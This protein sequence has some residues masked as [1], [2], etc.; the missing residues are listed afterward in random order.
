MEL[1]TIIMSQDLE[2]EIADMVSDAKVDCYVKMTDAYGVSHA[3]EGIIGE[4]ME[5]D[6][7][8][9]MITGER[10]NLEELAEKVQK[11]MSEKEFKPCVRMMLTPV[12]KVWM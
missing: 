10:K 1:L 8:L 9:M 11:K 2:H 7:T 6:A 4:N 12:D 5:W 3:C